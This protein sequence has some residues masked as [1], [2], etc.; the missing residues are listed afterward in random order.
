[1]GAGPG[2]Q[3]RDT[4]GDDEELDSKEV[5]A[6]ASTT[7]FDRTGRRRGGWRPRVPNETREPTVKTVRSWSATTNC[8]NEPLGQGD[9]KARPSKLFRS[10]DAMKPSRNERVRAK[11][12]RAPA[13]NEP[14]SSGLTRELE[15]LASQ[16]VSQVASLTFQAHT[17][18]PHHPA[19]CSSWL[20]GRRWRR[21]SR[22]FLQ[23]DIMMMA[24]TT[25]TPTR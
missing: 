20:R 6:A 23:T 4:D 17:Q 13:R 8:S 25:T 24:T 12:L 22:R 18:T 15:C 11:S 16:S 1:M 3:W 5:V 7:M 19:C 2:H 10:F 9:E 21:A 14:T